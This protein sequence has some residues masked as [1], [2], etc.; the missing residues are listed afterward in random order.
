MRTSGYINAMKQRIV[1]LA[2]SHGFIP[3]FIKPQRLDIWQEQKQ[4]LEYYGRLDKYD[5]DIQAQFP[6]ASSILLL[7]YPYKPFCRGEMVPAYYLASQR[8]YLGMLALRD[9]IS[10]LTRCERA[11]IPLRAA[12]LTA[13]IGIAC[14]CGLMSIPTLGTRFALQGLALEGVEPESYSCEQDEL[15]SK[16]S[17]CVNACPS[18]TIDAKMGLDP[19]RCI[20]AFMTSAPYPDWVKEKMTGYIG[21]E[22]C[23]WVCPRNA[24]L[25]VVKPTDVERAAFDT[26]RLLSG[27][28]A[29]ARRLAGKNFA[30]ATKM[31]YQ[32]EI[33]KERITDINRKIT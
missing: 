11:E 18:K 5:P 19:A 28:V 7:V 26:D 9:E 13:G 29:A 15:C 21:C 3:Y 20:R 8:A 6:F 17:A 12:A 10:E 25:E 23:Q 32:A 24:G 31:T 14:K 30:N 33:F 22:I 2:I 1:Q 16:C 4:R 27:D